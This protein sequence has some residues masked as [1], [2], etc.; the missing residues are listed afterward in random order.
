MDA[1]HF[2]TDSCRDQLSSVVQRHGGNE[3]FSI[4]VISEDGLVAEI[5][6]IA[7]G[8]DAAVPAPAQ[9]A[10]CGQVLIHNHP[11]GD[12]TPSDAD[13][14]LAALYGKSGIGFYIVDN[15]CNRV[16]VVVRP[17]VERPI[18]PVDM[19][20]VSDLFAPDGKLATSLSGYEHR[21]QQIQMMRLVADAF[22]GQHVAFVEAGTGVGKSFAYLTP[23]LL[24]AAANGRHVV[25]STNTINL[26]EQLMTKDIPELRR[27]LDI[28][29]KAVLLKGRGN[30]ISLRRLKFASAEAGLFSTNRD[31]ELRRLTDW[32]IRSTDG[33]R[34]DLAFEVSDDVWDAVQSDKD[35]CQR[36]RCPHF[37][38]CHYYNSRREAASADIIV[39]NH[40]LVLADLAIKR[41]NTGN[42][43]VAIIPPYD[44][45][46]FDEAHN[47]EEVATDYFGSQTSPL[48]IRR[49]LLKLI[50]HR[51]G[52]GALKTLFSN[53]LAVDGHARQTHTQKV[54]D[55]LDQIIPDLALEAEQAIDHHFDEI[56][57]RGLTFFNIP[58]LGPR[59]RREFR[60]TANVAASPYWSDA[61][62]GLEKVGES[63]EALVK[64]LARVLELLRGYRDEDAESI[65]DARL[66]VQS[67]AQK[68]TEHLG[69]LNFFRQAREEESCR[70]IELGFFRDRPAP[71]LCTA[72]L[73]VGPSMRQSLFERKKTV[74]L[75]SATLTVEKRFDFIARQLG[76]NTAA[77]EDEDPNIVAPVSAEP[78]LARVEARTRLLALGSPFDYA[79]NCLLGVPTD[80]THPS[81]PS[82]EAA[83]QEAILETLRLSGGSAFVLFTSYAMLERMHRNL[84]PILARE[85]MPPLRQGSMPRDRLLETFRVTPHG[86]LFATSSFWEGVDVQGKA[87]Q[88][89]VITKL[90][91]RVPTT[92]ILEAR[93][94]RIDQLGGNSFAELAIPL[95]VIRFKQGFGRLIRSKRDRG[96]VLVLDHRL[97]TKNYGRAFMRS[98]PPARVVADNTRAVMEEFGEFLR[99]D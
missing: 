27:R 91:F 58:K 44:H 85:A 5:E 10:H 69:S 73:N 31:E 12:L 79:N 92:P 15:D 70:W 20:M 59:E 48:A 68:L 13:I 96:V 97:A 60:I 88:C 39:A 36:A 89:L 33:S 90:P 47:L 18:I 45:I 35:D 4:G 63:L 55:H 95:A 62:E 34:S 76:I 66:K 30:Y 6:S 81:D 2:L 54:I 46:I 86:V 52:R 24:W 8:N 21:P 65:A 72:P 93:T 11:G 51:D 3:V 80:I 1:I 49:Q 42:D 84:A 19:E 64:A 78:D 25:I 87:L 56:F 32:A 67:I 98:L 77:I 23:A 43:F 61:E 9:D 94:E 82:F 38:D 37:N 99:V 74:V 57:H 17:F 28:Q 41:Q 26:Q 83:A 22:N 40:H 71:R 29:F 53:V 75:T 50:S 7:F 14:N 16:R